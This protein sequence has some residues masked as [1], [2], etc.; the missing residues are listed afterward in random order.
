MS[1][2]YCC[3]FSRF[4]VEDVQ[5]QLKSYTGIM[6]DSLKVNCSAVAVAVVRWGT[7]DATKESFAS[8]AQV[9][10]ALLRHKNVMAEYE[11]FNSKLEKL[12]ALLC[13]IQRTEIPEAT[14]CTTLVASSKIDYTASAAGLGN[15]KQFLDDSLER[16]IE[17]DEKKTD[18]VDM[19]MRII[20]RAQD[21]KNDL[22]TIVANTSHDELQELKGDLARKRHEWAALHEQLAELVVFTGELADLGVT[23]NPYTPYTLTDV[24]SLVTGAEDLFLQRA[25]DIGQESKQLEY[26]DDLRQRFAS[27]AEQV[28]TLL[29][30]C[31][32]RLTE[33]NDSILSSARDMM[34]KQ[35]ETAELIVATGEFTLHRSIWSIR[36]QSCA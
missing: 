15:R 22:S 16:Q 1:P 24:Q 28:N 11:A 10:A 30:S 23:K 33:L 19:A 18:W 20:T 36:S 27:S 25:N 7:Y 6:V 8:E 4:S 3:R 21:I 34:H 32:A 2:R 29:K 9:R 31:D 17:L 5:T 14:A 35:I 26:T 13:D 12:D